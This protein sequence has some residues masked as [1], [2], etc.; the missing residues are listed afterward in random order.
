MEP[1]RHLH[2]ELDR[3][4]APTIHRTMGRGGC[5]QQEWLVARD[6]MTRRFKE[7]SAA[8]KVESARAAAK[9]AEREKQLATA[10]GKVVQLERELAGA[11]AQVLEAKRGQLAAV[12]RVH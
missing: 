7:T 9:L 11:N 12:R 1:R 8:W 6:T 3:G 4:G 2:P 5:R 10:R